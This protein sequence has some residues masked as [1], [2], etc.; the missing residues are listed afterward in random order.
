MGDSLAI[1][2]VHTNGLCT[3][4][5]RTKVEE[6][7]RT[8]LSQRGLVPAKG[9]TEGGITV[10]VGCCGSNPWIEL[11][12]SEASCEDPRLLESMAAVLSRHCAAPVVSVAG[13]DVHGLELRLFNRG[14]RMEAW[15]LTGSNRDPEVGEGWW[16]VV[17]EGKNLEHLRQVLHG[18]QLAWQKALAE[19]SDVLGWEEVPPMGWS[20]LHYAF[21]S[22]VEGDA[23]LAARLEPDHLQSVVDV[24]VGGSFQVSASL[25]NMGRTAKGL[26][27][28]LE[29]SAIEQH[30]ALPQ[31]VHA[32]VATRSFTMSSADFRRTSGMFAPA[33]EPGAW[34]AVLPDV[35]LHPAPSLASRDLRVWRQREQWEI[36]IMVEG[37]AL[38]VG[39]GMLKVHVKPLGESEGHSICSVRFTVTPVHP[40]PLKALCELSGAD[41]ILRQL[42]RGT[43]LLA[44]V[45]LRGNRQDAANASLQAMEQWLR[46]LCGP[47]DGRLTALGM[48][49]A[50]A[51][52]ELLFNPSAEHGGADW[53]RVKLELAGLASFSARVGLAA[54]SGVSWQAGVV[55]AVPEAGQK[56]PHLG[57]WMGIPDHTPIQVGEARRLLKRLV[58]EVMGQGRGLQALVAEWAWEPEQ[59]VCPYEAACG[60]YGSITLRKFWCERYLH[61][62]GGEVWLGPSLRARIDERGLEGLADLEN[63][64]ESLRIS[65]RPG[66]A[67]R[68]VETALSAVLPVETDWQEGQRDLGELVRA[69]GS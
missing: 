10:T 34:V 60:I 15:S 31:Q 30:M 58:D 53:E 38:V 17:G 18:R 52:S 51:T 24:E 67:M 62:V 7:V 1:V 45:V 59:E 22:T 14:R 25:V 48:G 49:G 26:E 13:S 4:Q 21:P 50:L 63:L 35:E 54:S 64:G 23:L 20:P 2:R 55:E 57:L 19:W 65:V 36:H 6:S 44:W 29:G 33:A 32:S 66:T 37:T 9:T 12:S 5:V 68:E 40:R 69:R 3:S 46:F 39:E 41:E 47:G 61:G 27:V 43:T 28:W 56:V 8:W 11:L 42:A 16:S